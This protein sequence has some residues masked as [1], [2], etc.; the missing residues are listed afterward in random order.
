ML[1]DVLSVEIINK[2]GNIVKSAINEYLL[3][4]LSKPENA[5]VVPFS[6]SHGDGRLDAQVPVAIKMSVREGNALS[7]KIEVADKYKIRT[8][9]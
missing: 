4:D 3:V 9:F 2:E 5:Q 7:Y 6:F 8:I 1:S